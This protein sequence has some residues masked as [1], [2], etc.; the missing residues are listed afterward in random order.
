MPVMPDH[1]DRESLI[2][3][4]AL[5]GR[6][7]GSRKWHHRAALQIFPEKFGAGKFFW[8]KLS[9][10]LGLMDWNLRGYL[11]GR[12]RAKLPSPASASV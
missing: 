2:A 3:K 5:R 11:H 1:A 8:E 4:T 7:R 9:P 10:D 6:A 12:T